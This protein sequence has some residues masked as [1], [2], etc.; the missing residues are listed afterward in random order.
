MQLSVAMYRWDPPRGGGRGGPDPPG[1]SQVIWVSIGNKQLDP[2]PWKKL[3]PLWNLEKYRFLWNW[4]FDFCIFCQ[5][6]L[7][8]LLTKIPESA[9]VFF[10]LFSSFFS[11]WGSLRLFFDLVAAVR[12]ASLSPQQ[13]NKCWQRWFRSDESTQWFYGF[14]IMTIMKHMIK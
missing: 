2:P 6:D 8:P 14:P 11:Q 3:D 5:A 13:Q 1:K 7:D 4:P 9:H 12:R 10:F